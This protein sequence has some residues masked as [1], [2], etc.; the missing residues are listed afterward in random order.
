ML[1]YGAE[2]PLGAHGGALPV[3]YSLLAA[4]V[5][6][7]SVSTVSLSVSVFSL[8]VLTARSSQYSTGKNATKAGD[9]AKENIGALTMSALSAEEM[10]QLG[11]LQL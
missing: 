5:D 11:N 6:S 10:A 9:Y 7:S 3:F 8:S 1:V 4:S 2:P